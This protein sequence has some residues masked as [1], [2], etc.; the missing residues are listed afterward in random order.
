MALNRDT[1]LLFYKIVSE[2]LSLSNN[3]KQRK[4]KKAKLATPLP[5]HC[6]RVTYVLSTDTPEKVATKETSSALSG[7]LP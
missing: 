1:K 5:L 7:S 4:E 3:I 6:E 2:I